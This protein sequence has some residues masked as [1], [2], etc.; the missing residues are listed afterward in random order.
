MN[1]NFSKISWSPNFEQT[2]IPKTVKPVIRPPQPNP[3]KKW[4]MIAML[5]VA[6]NVLFLIVAIVGFI[7]VY[8]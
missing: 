4:V 1:V 2:V 7:I 3:N 6:I 8:S 5:Q